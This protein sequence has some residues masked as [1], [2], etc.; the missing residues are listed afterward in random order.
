MIPSMLRFW[1]LA[2]AWRVGGRAGSVPFPSHSS[3]DLVSRLVGGAWLG[4]ASRVSVFPTDLVALALWHRTLTKKKRYIIHNT[5]AYV[6]VYRGHAYSTDTFTYLFVL[7]IARGGR[8]TSD[9]LLF[10]LGC[11]RRRGGRFGELGAIFWCRREILGY[12]IFNV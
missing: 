1:A 9:E 6:Y 5:F 11:S 2:P 3:R 7:F 8:Q 12:R 10:L 4:Y